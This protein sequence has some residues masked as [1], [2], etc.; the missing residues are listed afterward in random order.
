MSAN[1]SQSCVCTG[2]V[3]THEPD[4]AVNVPWGILL[5]REESSA[6]VNCTL[7]NY[8]KNVNRLAMF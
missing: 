7:T 5:I 6:K 2:N 8:K 1:S 4:T 3:S